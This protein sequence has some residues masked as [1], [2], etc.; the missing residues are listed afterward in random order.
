MNGAMLSA[1]GRPI[2]R[3]AYP[4]LTWPAV[5]VGWLIGSI[6]TVA[7][8]YSALIL[9]FSIEGN[10]LAA[11]LG[12][13]ILR[14]IMR[15]SSIIENNIN[16]TLAVSVNGASAG[17]MFTIPALFILA[18]QD[19]DRYAQARNFSQLLMV[20]SC[21]AGGILGICFVIPLRKQMIDFNRLAYPGGIAAA[22]ILKSPGAGM[23]KAVMLFGA[24]LLSAAAF[25]WLAGMFGEE[26]EGPLGRLLRL[27]AYLNITFFL[28]LMTLGVGFLSGKHGLV[29]TYGGF[30]CYWVLAPLLANFGSPDV[31]EMADP[32]RRMAFV[33]QTNAGEVEKALRL[34]EGLN[35][36]L[37]AEVRAATDSDQI[38]AA[39]Q[40]ERKRDWTPPFWGEIVSKHSI[41]DYAAAEK[42][43]AA[44]D[45]LK[46]AAEAAKLRENADKEAGGA[47]ASPATSQASPAPPTSAALEAAERALRVGTG[48]G[49]ALASQ[50][51]LNK[52][53]Q[54]EQDGFT[55]LHQAAT[56]DRLL[57]SEG[58]PAETAQRLRE[59]TGTE[60]RLIRAPE[61]LRVKQFRPIG[62][63]IL[64][65][66]AIGGIIA[67]FPL[68][69]SAIRS[70]QDA[71]KKKSKS[72]G[73]ELPVG[74]LYGAV[75]A[76]GV[77]LVLVARFAVL[78]MPWWRAA[79]VA[80]LG[81][82]W[83]WIA[84]VIVSESLG[85]TNW[86]PLSG[87]T[88]IAVTLLIVACTAGKDP[89]PPLKTVVVSVIA[90]AAICVAIAQAGGMMMDLKAGYLVGA[91]PRMQQ[92]AQ[93]AGTWLGPLIL[94]VLIGVLAKQGFG[95]GKLAAPQASA[96]AAVMNSLIGGD[97][98][99]W[100]YTAGG[101]IG[102]L[103]AMSGLG[104]IGVQIGL[105][106]Y[107]PFSVVLTYS[108]GVAL[109]MIADRVMGHRWIEAA[110]IPLA[111]G[112]VVGESLA[113]V[114]HTFYHL[115]VKA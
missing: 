14:G 51:A 49:A 12:W 63:G 39:L 114:G 53:R 27:P 4:E 50:D 84:G 58:L 76:A 82:L 70:M 9:G 44:A 36:A 54:L 24:T 28:S 23:R 17:M 10:E 110:G 102:L 115:L 22:A 66:A 34:V 71:T 98:P 91:R 92:Y 85:R 113:H 41:Y 61:E 32:P 89:L 25:F 16:Q 55:G 111:A 107:L 67:A 7:I 65:G 108:V 19:P 37:A 18:D 56:L 104:G 69:M 112:L 21:I 33:D 103:L 5:I 87:M 52:V 90:G 35:P 38:V 60:K 88:L 86:S 97:A 59:A 42:L 72:G 64:I 74:L 29:F 47:A 31:R 57:D 40:R 13:G 3:G 68:V 73:D 100:R 15:R 62:I 46:E 8:G 80:V 83:I 94:I 79:L 20:L 101:G 96:L 106:F 45:V 43:V 95:E 105:G 1:D 11:I 26:R 75:L 109:R 93:L 6:L 48:A 77:V 78:D 99:N 30:I 81:V 2:R